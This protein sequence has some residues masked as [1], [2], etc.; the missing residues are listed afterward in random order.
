MDARALGHELKELR[1]TV[2]YLEGLV[3]GLQY[4]IRSRD[5]RIGR[6][7]EENERL[8]ERLQEQAPPPPPPASPPPFVKPNQPA[9]RRK[10]P[11]RK[12]GHEA[13][14]RPPPDR[15]DR[16][17]EVPLRRGRTWSGRR[18]RRPLCPNCRA[19]LRPGTLR[20]HR[21]VVEDLV[22][23]RVEVTCYHTRSGYCPNCRGR[24][25]SRHPGQPPPAGLPH[26]RLGVNALAE[27]AA[28]RVENRLPMR[29]VCSVLA[30]AGLRLCAGAVARQA[31]TLARW[32]A[33][34]CEAIGLRLRRSPSV[35]A[36]ETGWRTRGRNT[37]VWC[38]CA[39]RH[40]LY[41]VDPSRAGHVARGLLGGN[42]GGTVACDF[43]GAYDAAGFERKQRCLAHLLRELKETARDS[44]AFAAGSFHPRCRRLLKDMLALKK[45]WHEL[46]DAAYTRRAC[47]IE[48]RLD[49]LARAHACEPEPH[50][51]RLAAR[52]LRHRRELTPFLWDEHLDGTNNAAERALRPAV[53]MRKVTGGSRSEAGAHAWAV[54]ATVLRTARQQGR[55]AVGTLKALM[56]RHWAGEGP[57]LLTAD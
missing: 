10:R 56:M 27:A 37:W 4:E 51:K 12:A 33:G 13:A 25:E 28:L 45:R 11:G 29:Q 9:G 17:V 21:R 39:A 38:V 18:T 30:R 31:R 16:H 47:R 53:V 6:L 50:A 57:G 5:C 24:V 20:R 14:L 49:A 54:L 40:T 48:D 32:L 1:L 41:H 46:G 43:Y 36:D 42:F 15:I 35:H 19:P 3:G 7:E 22:P 8:R 34:E 52:L 23:A 44:P 55:D 2:Q 26:A